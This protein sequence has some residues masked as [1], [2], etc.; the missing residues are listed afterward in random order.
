MKLRT[1]SLELDGETYSVKDF[2]AWKGQLAKQEDARNEV[3]TAR[4]EVAL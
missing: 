1:S 2:K 3:E 4:Q